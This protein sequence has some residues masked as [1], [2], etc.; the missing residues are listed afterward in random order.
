VVDVLV[1][2]GTPEGAEGG[3]RGEVVD[4]ERGGVAPENRPAT[5]ATMQ[6]GR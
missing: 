4:R 6:E 1:P 3:K 5:I 2:L